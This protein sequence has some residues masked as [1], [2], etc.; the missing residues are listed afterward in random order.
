MAFSGYLNSVLV[1]VFGAITLDA[2]GQTDALKNEVGATFLHTLEYSLGGRGG[3]VAAGL[4]CLGIPA[5]LLAPVGK[6]FEKPTTFSESEL[7]VL[8]TSLT[9]RVFLFQGPQATRVY[10]YVEMT[11]KERASFSE[12]TKARLDQ[13][14]H[15]LVVTSELEP[16]SL[17]VIAQSKAALK[18]FAP[19]HRVV[20]FEKKSLQTA[21]GQVNVLCVNADEADILVG[22]LDKS[23]GDIHSSYGLLYTVITEGAHGATLLTGNEKFHLPA[24]P[25]QKVDASGAGDSLAAAFIGSLLKGCS[26]HTGLGLGLALSAYVVEK[27]GCQTNLPAW[28]PL[29]TR[30]R[31]AYGEGVIPPGLEAK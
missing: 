21:L 28:A 15:G 13:R 23:I 9:P 24:T 10:A 11:P 31:K 14:A 12:W 6:D 26:P 25:A 18:L 2:I 20:D 30:A 17:D 27:R 4:T 19:A 7:F 1:T 22:R 8:E 5:Q 29:V 3:N 16:E